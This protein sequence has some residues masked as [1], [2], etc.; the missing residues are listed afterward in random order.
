M[1]KSSVFRNEMHLGFAVNCIANDV[2]NYLE[3]F[4]HPEVVS[5]DY[6]SHYWVVRMQLFLTF[7]AKRQ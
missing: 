4:V 5:G 3:L 2:G 6:R 1:P 7:H